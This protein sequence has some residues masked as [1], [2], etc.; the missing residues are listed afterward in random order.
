MIFRRSKNRWSESNDGIEDVSEN[1]K[2]FY[3]LDFTR[4]RFFLFQRKNFQERHDRQYYYDEQIR[5]CRRRSVRG[6]RMAPLL[7]RR[8]VHSIDSAGIG[9]FTSFY[10]SNMNGEDPFAW[11]SYVVSLCYQKLHRGIETSSM[12]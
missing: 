5:Q 9:L 12:I 1:R 6:R 3:L 2:W 11:T 7:T 10:A 8:L 4:I